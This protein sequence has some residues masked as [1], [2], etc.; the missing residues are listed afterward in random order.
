MV[1]IVHLRNQLKSINTFERSCDYNLTL[2]RSE[3]KTQYLLFKNWMVLIC[4]N[5]SFFT[6]GCFMPGLVAIGLGVIEKMIYNVVNVF[7]LLYYLP[8]EKG[9]LLHLNEVESLLPKNAL[10]WNWPSGSGEEDENVKSFR[11]TDNRDQK[12]SF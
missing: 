3:G 6:Q 7:W 9:Q 12:S 8:L 11:Q 2:I 4:K 1:H 5:L 10:C